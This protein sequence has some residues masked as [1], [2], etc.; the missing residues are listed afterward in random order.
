MQRIVLFLA[1]LAVG[2]AVGLMGFFAT[3]SQWWYLAIP[4]AMAA[5]WLVVANP[6]H[7]MAIE[8]QVKSGGSSA[9]KPLHRT[10]GQ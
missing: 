7:C 5:G 6:E 4:G 1:C 9:T 2:L 10:H 3:G 8:R